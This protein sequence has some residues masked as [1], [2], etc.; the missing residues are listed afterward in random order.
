MFPHFIAFLP[1]ILV[2]LPVKSIEELSDIGIELSRKGAWKD[3]DSDLFPIKNGGA[4]VNVVN[5]GP[6]VAAP[7]LSWVDSKL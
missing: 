1:R 7:A 3:N 4:S 2:D 6:V 5:N